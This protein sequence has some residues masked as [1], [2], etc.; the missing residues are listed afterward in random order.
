MRDNLECEEVPIK[1]YLRRRDREDRR[2]EIKTST[3]EAVGKEKLLDVD[4]KD[5]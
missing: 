2:D 3:R 1:L 4:W 5:T